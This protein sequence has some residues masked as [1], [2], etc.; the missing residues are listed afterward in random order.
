MSIL[1]RF[2]QLNTVNNGSILGIGTAV[3]I[4]VKVREGARSE[5]SWSASGAVEGAGVGLE[6]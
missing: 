1:A 2:W 4:W 6:S 3:G 5:G